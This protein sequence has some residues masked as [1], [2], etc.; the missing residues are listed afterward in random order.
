[1]TMRIIF[2]GTP[3]FAVPILQK[4]IDSEHEVIAVY[5]QPDRPAGR[6]RKLQISPVK[7][8][9][10][11]KNIPVYQP[12]SFKDENAIE[13][14]KKLKPDLMV[15]AV[16]GLLL[17]KVVLETPRLG[18]V[19]VHI[20]LLPRWRGASPN[21][22]PILAGDKKTGV[23][24]MQM[25][26]GLDTGDMLYKKEYVIEPTDTAKDLRDKLI[27]LGAQALIE[28][29][30]EIEKGTVKR[31]KQ[32]DAQATH[33]PKIKKEDAEID[34]KK[35][36]D[37]ISRMVRAYN[38]W[39]VAFTY[40]KDELI[41]IWEA[42]SIIDTLVGHPGQVLNCGKDGIDVAAG[43]GLL[44][45]KKLQLAGK[46]IL[47]AQEFLNGNSDWFKVGICLG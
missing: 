15:V 25:D 6:G 1:M 7:E 47:S 4:L 30:P 46:K 33:A 45:I 27:V 17:P 43:V 5:T 10:Q 29:L 8:L 36:A 28:V 37:E 26:K 13:D 18:C 35:S 14:L 23:T 41:K 16:Y 3:D 9:A 21:V 22:Q 32:N 34:W 40:Y 31:Q 19:N 42:E 20:S 2:A 12:A 38:P 11:S 24:I 44:R 39:P